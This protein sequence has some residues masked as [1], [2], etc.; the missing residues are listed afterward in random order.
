MPT[1]K[2]VDLIRVIRK[3]SAWPQQPRSR[4]NERLGKVDAVDHGLLKLLFTC[5]VGVKKHSI[6]F[7]QAL[8]HLLPTP[9]NEAGT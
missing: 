6:T 4:G 2:R 3:Y 5:R 7:R 1:T 9:L 8:D